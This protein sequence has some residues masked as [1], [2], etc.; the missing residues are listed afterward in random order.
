MDF[1]FTLQWSASDASIANSTARLFRTGK[2]PGMPRQTGH[3][4]VFGGAPKLVG[5]PQKIFVFVAS[6]TWTSSPITGSYLAMRAGE[7][8]IISLDG[9]SHYKGV[10]FRR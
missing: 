8:S 1:A 9:M 6:W 5:H 7:A 10:R 2:A 4:L 3:T